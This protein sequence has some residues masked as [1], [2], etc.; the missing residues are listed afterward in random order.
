[1]NKYLGL[2]LLFSFNIIIAQQGENK[3]TYQFLKKIDDNTYLNDVK[4]KFN[5]KIL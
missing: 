5:L 4:N 3:S 2:L 1:M